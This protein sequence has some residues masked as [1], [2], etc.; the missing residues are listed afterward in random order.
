[1][2]SAYLLGLAPRLEWNTAILPYTYASP[3]QPAQQFDIDMRSGARTLRKTQE[4]PSGHDPARYVTHRLHAPAADGELVPVTVLMRRDT[5][6]DGSAPMFLYGYGSYGMAM[7]P[8]FSI[9]ALSLVDRGW[10]WATAHVRGGSE[11]GYGWFLGGRGKHKPNTFTDFIAAA[12]HLIAQGYGRAGAHR[13][14]RRLGRRPAV[15]AAVLN[16]RPDLWAGV[17]RRG[18]RSSTCSTRCPTTRCR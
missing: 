5:P 8:G 7:Q 4:I 15:W 13:R 11:K 3:T 9:Q 6:R 10:V 1:M 16:L 2:S 18:G 14:K 12:E 17:G